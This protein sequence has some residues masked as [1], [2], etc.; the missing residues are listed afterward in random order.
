[1]PSARVADVD[2]MVVVEPSC[3]ATATCEPGF[4]DEGTVSILVVQ[5]VEMGRPSSVF[6]HC[7]RTKGETTAIRVLWALCGG[8]LCGV[9]C[10][11]LCGLLCGAVCGLCCGLLCGVALA[12][13]L[14]FGRPTDCE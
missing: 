8:L 6:A 9:C 3:L 2:R 4:P 14:P 7:D 13:A 10:G 5:G 12:P 11:L 1:M